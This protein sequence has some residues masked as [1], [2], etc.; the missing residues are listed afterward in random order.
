MRWFTVYLKPFK[1]DDVL[2]ALLAFGVETPG[3]IRA[4]T[5]EPVRGYGR[6]KGH[7]E[8]Y[9][10]DGDRMTF[11]PK[12]RLEFAAPRSREREIID[13][14]REAARTGRIGDGKILVRELRAHHPLADGG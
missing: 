10:D 11:L 8:L 13:A 5:V 12:L 4:L 1:F 9:R 2:E 6:Q 7:L 14:V 3:G